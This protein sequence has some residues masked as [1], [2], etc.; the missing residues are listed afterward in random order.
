MSNSRVYLT[1]AAADA[2]PVPEFHGLVRDR[3]DSAVSYFEAESA[4]VDDDHGWIRVRVADE[5]KGSRMIIFPPT[6]V[7][8][9]VRL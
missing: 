4:T 9:V 8:A 5:E 7:A 3:V 2:L 1:Q 6:A